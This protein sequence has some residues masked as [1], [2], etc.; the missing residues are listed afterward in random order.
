MPDY[1]RHPDFATGLPTPNFGL[2]PQ[3]AFI[4]GQTQL[5]KAKFYLTE[6]AL[7][8]TY[9]YNRIHRPIS[10]SAVR[11]T[12]EMN[13]CDVQLIQR[14]NVQGGLRKKLGHRLM[15]IILSNLK[16]FTTFF[17]GEFGKFAV[18]CILKINR[19]LHMLL[20]YLVKH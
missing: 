1:W 6:F 2:M 17:Q 13:T 10:R 12:C 15:T 4:L 11:N 16:R 5:K 14:L 8:L 20:H 7:L 19:A 18:K 3:F 9:V